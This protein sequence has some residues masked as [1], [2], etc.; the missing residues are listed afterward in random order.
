MDEGEI[1][2]MLANRSIQFAGTDTTLSPEQRAQMPDA[3]LLPSLAQAVVIGYNLPGFTDL[4]LQIPREAL[5]A[6]FLG[7][8]RMWSEAGG[9][10][11]SYRALSSKSSWSCDPTEPERRTL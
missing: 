10:E 6:V 1:G 3:W 8:I 2:I 9:V 7:R 11:P 4:E 5:A